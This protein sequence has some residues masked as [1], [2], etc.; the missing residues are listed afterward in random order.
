[1]KRTMLFGYL[2]T[3]VAA[4]AFSTS[5]TPIEEEIE[6]TAELTRLDQLIFDSAFLTCDEEALYATMSDDLEFY[7][8]IYG[9]IAEDLNSC[10]TGTITDC[11]ARKKRNCRILSGGS[12]QIR[13]WFD[14]WEIG[15][16]CNLAVI[17]SIVEMNM[18][19]T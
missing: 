7:H 3:L 19:T 9:L 13:C 10:V 1:M 4:F 15:A 8:D 14:L 12:S 16:H 18:E 17:H 11:V 6:L 5:A 2:T